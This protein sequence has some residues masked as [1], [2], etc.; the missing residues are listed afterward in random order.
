MLMLSNADQASVQYIRRPVSLPH[1]LL[2]SAAPCDIF[3][4]RGTLIVKAGSIIPPRIQD[5]SLPARIFCQAR[6]ADQIS[7]VDPTAELQQLGLKLSAMAERL[8]RQAAVSALE[9][10]ALARW[11]YELWL[12]DADACLGYARLAKFAR[13]SVGHVIHVALIAAE[14]AKANGL[15]RD[16]VESL[17]GA[18]LTMNVAKLSL[19]DAMYT[20]DGAPTPAMR[21]EIEA[22]P[23]ASAALLCGIG[24]IN[25]DWSDAV[26]YH[27][28]N[29]DGSGYPEGLKGTAIPL[30]ARMMRVA[31]TL[32]ARLTGR[33]A[34]PP[35]HWNVHYAR[36]LRHLVSHVF[37]ADEAHLDSSL[38]H[39]LLRTL[40]RFAPG[41]LL[42][43]STHELA[44]VTRRVPGQSLGPRL[45][46]A[47]CDAH[48]LVYETPQLRQ[49]AT[50]QCEIRGYAHDA[51]PKLNGVDW[52]KAWGYG[53]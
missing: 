7:V 32:A 21:G 44:I 40:N 23:R 52:A 48:G 20:W 17:I 42:R 12:L 24:G 38:T 50:R 16:A 37:G 51:L 10:E 2:G 11:M 28:E 4:A 49:I 43:L 13:P 46:F 26:A 29:I 31:D 8:N 6:E 33:K 3:S 25:K 36:D 19:H 14:L 34:R 5:T 18:A 22:H 35:R 41:S 9:L 39:R 27:H 30:P 47:V 15:Q 1:S 53:W 45:V